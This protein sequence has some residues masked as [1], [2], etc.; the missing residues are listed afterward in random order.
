MSSFQTAVPYDYAFGLPGE[1]KYSGPVRAKPGYINSASAAYNIVGATIFT[2]PNSGG[3][4]AAGGAIAAGTTFY[5]LLANPKLY[6]SFGTT[7]GGPLA[8]TMTLPN[9]IEAEF[10]TMGEVVVSVP[11]PCNIGDL[12][13]YNT[14]TGA[15]GTVA[16]SAA[17]TGVV[18]TSTL[19]VSGMGATGNLGVGSVLYSSTGAILARILALG[20]GTGGNGTYTVDTTTVSSQAM[21]ANS[22]PA[23]GFAFVPNAVITKFPQTTAGAGI[24]LA[25]FTN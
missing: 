18:A 9:L 16:P 6:A 11:G 14:T 2:S 22:E 17:F 24:A 15:I 10:L 21:T 13:T 5:G 8:P 19:T 4:V 3:T 1:I 20:T 12:L 7:A 23:S 25:S